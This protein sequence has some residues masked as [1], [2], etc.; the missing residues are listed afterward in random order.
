[1]ATFPCKTLLLPLGVVGLAT[2]RLEIEEGS[3]ALP[4]EKL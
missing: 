1:M 3:I 2:A 4:V